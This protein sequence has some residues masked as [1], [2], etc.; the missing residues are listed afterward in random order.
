MNEKFWD[1]IAANYNKEIFDTL[2]HDRNDTIAQHIHRFRS[3]EAV[4]CDF[5]CGTGKYLPFLGERFKSVYAIDLSSECLHMARKSGQGLENIT[6]LKSNLADAE[7]QMGIIDFALSVNVLIMPSLKVR[8]SILKN[9]FE[10]TRKQ[11]HF[12]MVVPSLESALFTH[13]R[14]LEW[15]ERSKAWRNGVMWQSIITRDLPVKS[16]A[17]GL[18]KLDGVET[19]HYLREELQ[20]QLRSVGFEVLSTRKVEYSWSTEFDQPPPWMKEPYP[21]DWLAL[22]EKK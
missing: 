9:V 10:H 2:K 15:H 3:K 13:S 17:T 18:L 8:N 1:R 12:L 19:K 22:C 21:W 11:G 4:A 6:Y 16:V 7:L 20:V 5:G 14:L